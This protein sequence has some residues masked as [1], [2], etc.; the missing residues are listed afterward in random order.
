[1]SELFSPSLARRGLDRLLETH[2]H[3][4]LVR[5]EWQESGPWLLVELGQ[6]STNGGPPWAVHPYAIF[7]RTGAVH[8]MIGGAVT[9]DPILEP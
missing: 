7:K 2:P 6:A 5:A 9:D 4:E 8:G 1:V 3:L